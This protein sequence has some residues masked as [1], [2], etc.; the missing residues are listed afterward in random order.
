MLGLA[1]CTHA[2]GKTKKFQFSFPICDALAWICL[3]KFLCFCYNFISLAK[4]KALP[5]IAQNRTSLERI[6]PFILLQT[7]VPVATS[8]LK[9]HNM[10]SLVACGF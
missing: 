4:A 7:K 3:L 9:K 2:A 6:W 8:D 10:V 1:C 5:K